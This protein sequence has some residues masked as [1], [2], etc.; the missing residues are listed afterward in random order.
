MP[1]E[2]EEVELALDHRCRL[3]VVHGICLMALFVTLQINAAELEYSPQLK[4]APLKGLL[5]TTNNSHTLEWY[6]VQLNSTMLGPHEFDWKYLDKRLE[7]AS[8]AGRTTIVR[9]VM[10]LLSQYPRL[11]YYLTNIPGATYQVTN[12]H[13]FYNYPK[14]GIVPVYT[15]EAMRTAMTL[16]IRAFGARYDGDPRIAFVE[17]GL[18]GT[19]GEW[20]NINLSRY[21][22]TS[23][24]LE[25]KQEIFQA[26]QESFKQTKVLMRWPEAELAALPFGY[27]DDWFAYWNIPDSLYRRQTKAGPEALQR[28]RTHPIGSRLHPDFDT[29]FK[30]NSLNLSDVS[31]DKLLALIQRDHISWL[32]YPTSSLKKIPA[33]VIANLSTLGPK[34]GYELYAPKANWKRDTINQTLQISVTITNAGV[35]PFYYP[36]KMEAGLSSDKQLLETWPLKWDITRVIPNEAAITY[37]VTLPDFEPKRKDAHLLIRVVNPLKTGPPLRFANQTQDADLDGWLTLGSVGSD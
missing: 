30:V 22:Q 4:P 5:H 13:H 36:W 1:E 2:V 17:A 16:F 29:D 7:A 33:A 27:H 14:G 25:L 23:V 15:N 37:T 32:R 31:E 9:P 34:T 18:V 28:W 20:Y 19:W 26:Y 3:A 21:P 10:D 35:A 11:P 12:E 6:N 8:A 24:P